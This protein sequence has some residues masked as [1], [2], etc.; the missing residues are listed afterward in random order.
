MPALVAAADIVVVP[1]KL[2]IPGAVPSK[3]YEAHVLRAGASC[4]RPPERLP[5]SFLGTRLASSW[6][7]GTSAKAFTRS[8]WILLAI[9]PIAKSWERRFAAATSDAGQHHAAIDIFG[10]LESA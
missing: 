2:H 4:Y 8:L 9:C 10:L 3:L 1:L 7:L 5:T 6:P